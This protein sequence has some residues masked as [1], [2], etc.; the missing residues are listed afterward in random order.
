MVI[1]NT[2]YTKREI[3][4]MLEA[5]HA[6]KLSI[7]QEKLLEISDKIYLFDGIKKEDIIRMTVN[8]K[9]KRYAKGDVIMNAGD[10]G[11][12]IYFI[13]YGTAVVV[14]EGKKIVATIDSPHM[15]GE[16]AFLTKKP[17]N[18]TI[19]AYKEGTTIISFEVN[20]EKCSEIFSYPFAQL[21]R[22]IALD[23]TGKIEKT[24]LKK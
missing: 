9:F 24:N 20:D 11:R 8:V 7:S 2:N 17:R 19:L 6:N 23:L 14:V 22:N 5:G 16:M 12:E 15:F 4:R 13:L 18:A 3:E 1:K 10:K 21:Y